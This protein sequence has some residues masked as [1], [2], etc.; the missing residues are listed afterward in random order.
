MKIRIVVSI[1]ILLMVSI[2]GCVKIYTSPPQDEATVVP[3]QVQNAQEE[4]QQ[5]P[6]PKQEQEVQAPL[7]DL[8]PTEILYDKSA[9]MVGT[10]VFFD[11][12]ISNNGLADADGFNI[13]WFVNGEEMGYGGH[14][15]VK[16][17]FQDMTN[18]SQFYWMPVSAGNY[19]VEFVIDC[20]DFIHEIKEDNNSVHVN[21]LVEGDS[22]GETP[23]RLG[24]GDTLFDVYTEK[25][26]VD[27]DGDGNLDRI[28]YHAGE[29]ITINGGVY[30][31]THENYAQSFA[32]VD[33]SKS[34]RHLEILL[35]PKYRNYSGYADCPSS[36]LCWWDGEII[37]G[38]GMKGI[39]FDG[40]WGADFSPEEFFFGNY[41]VTFLTPKNDNSGYYWGY[42]AFDPLNYRFNEIR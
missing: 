10:T 35:N 7:P 14:Q 20:D 42:F 23:I 33:I 36:W 6:E 22:W 34:D 31:S 21:V 37:H 29:T 19:E 28:E 18:N 4:S 3:E 2:F 27:L 17:G 38:F 40:N 11:S 9:L 24:N 26:E 39:L 1:S 30:P 5:E 13:K 41:R 25:A 12:G 15:G 8:V 32:I 16:A